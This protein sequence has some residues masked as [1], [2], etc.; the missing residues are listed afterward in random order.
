MQSERNMAGLPMLQCRI[1]TSVDSIL[2]QDNRYMPASFVITVF[3]RNV[4][5]SG[6]QPL[7]TAIA[8]DIR[9]SLIQDVQ[10]Q[11][12]GLP[13]RQLVNPSTG[14]SELHFGE[15]L[16]VQFEV[17]PSGPRTI[18]S[19]I[20]LSSIAV[21]ANAAYA[22]CKSEVWVERAP[23]PRLEPFCSTD[24]DSIVWDGRLGDYRPNPFPIKVRVTNTGDDTS[25]S[26]KVMY[27]GTP[28]VTLFELDEAV[29]DIGSL[30]PGESASV[31]FLL[32]PLP[33]SVGGVV[34][35]CFQVQGK[36]GFGSQ[37]V[38]DTCCIDVY[39]P[40]ATL[41]ELDVICDLEVD[42]LIFRDGRYEP[43][44]FRFS[45]T[46][47]NTGMAI[48]RNIAAS[49]ELPP[50]L[51]LQPGQRVTRK[52]DSLL[53]S[54]STTLSWLLRPVASKQRETYRICASVFDGLGNRQRCCDSIVVPPVRASAIELSCVCPDTLHVDATNGTYIDNP[55]DVTL[56]VHN[57][58]EAAADSLRGTLLIASSLLAPLSEDA[59]AERLD[60]GDECVFR[61]TLEAFPT[62]VGRTVELVFLLQ[63]DNGL[64]KECR[65]S[66]YIEPMPAPML[67]SNC[68]TLPSGQLEVDP[69][70][71]GYFPSTV[72][73]RLCVRNTGGAPLQDLTAT[74]SLPPH[75]R[76]TEGESAELSFPATIPPQAERCVEWSLTPLRLTGDGYDADLFAVLLSPSVAPAESAHCSLYIP[77][78]PGTAAL[79]VSRNAIGYAGND[80]F[81]PLSI[82]DPSGKD[83]EKL[84]ITLMYNHDDL[85]NR[86]TDDVLKFVDVSTEGCLTA[87]WNILRQHG[88]LENDR[89]EFT[90][91]APA[92]SVLTYP[93]GETIPPLVQLRFHVLF[94][95]HPD[96]L[97]WTTA[98]ILW[99]EP[100]SLIS[101]VR[102]NDG[103]YLPRCSDGLAT[104][105]GDCLR[106]LVEAHRYD[107]HA[108][109][110]PFNPS[111]DIV[112]TLQSFEHVRVFLTDA[113]GRTVAELVDASMEA[114]VH[115]L[116]FQAGDLP[117]G[118][119][120][121]HLRTE[122]TIQTSRML[123]L[124]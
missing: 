103:E 101:D 65:C 7:D 74:L 19:A 124:K 115:R 114:G 68:S 40:P 116:H 62:V 58:G 11:I 26:T 6:P 99:P 59:F 66:I 100:A 102:I 109:P 4:G 44:P 23:A 42:S 72:T 22:I 24:F 84:D 54:E 88:N 43:D 77:P 93:P 53:P 117:A 83:I 69:R 28:E 91:E 113:L 31:T 35:P 71:G 9:V 63:Y 85:R 112:F 25:D 64:Q 1:E 36:G 86:L 37:Y 12:I 2:Y 49:V 47:V 98:P 45:L 75:L 48:S 81:V 20:A 29:K 104:L 16:S 30:E 80:L 56:R 123:L 8:R 96:E 18:S 32:R 3:V 87:G 119:Y 41:P 39:I 121:C 108:T 120:Y 106:P 14:R 78:L 111:T 110:N 76:L 60:P 67:E 70:T 92:G 57:T 95:A 15:E 122:S 21:S 17:Q 97:D 50:G 27:I 82:D 10:F 13:S 46:V 52:V 90:L 105:S 118:V 79:S 94:G 5:E 55:F 89:L 107:L 33:R 61:W 34:T 38:I 51:Y 73:Y